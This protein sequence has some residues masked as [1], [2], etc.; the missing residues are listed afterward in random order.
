LA[1]FSV[2]ESQN[3]CQRPGKAAQEKIRFA[4]RALGDDDP[5]SR[6]EQTEVELDVYVHPRRAA[7]GISLVIRHLRQ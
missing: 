2:I 7:G 4:F 3:P 5:P 1:P 6:N